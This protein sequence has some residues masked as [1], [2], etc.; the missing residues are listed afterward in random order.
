MH[1]EG[2]SNRNRFLKF[3]TCQYDF[4]INKQ[5]QIMNNSNIFLFRCK[6]NVNALSALKYRIAKGFQFLLCAGDAEHIFDGII[7]SNIDEFKLFLSIVAAHCQCE[8]IFQTNIRALYATNANVV[9]VHQ[10]CTSPIVFPHFECTVCGSC[11]HHAAVRMIHNNATDFFVVSVHWPNGCAF[12]S[13][14]AVV[15]FPRV[16]RRKIIV[17]IVRIP[18]H[19]FDFTAGECPEFETAVDRI[20]IAT[21]EQFHCTVTAAGQQHLRFG[22]M[23][24]QCLN[25]FG[26]WF[27]R[28]VR[29]SFV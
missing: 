26:K 13:N 7:V 22:L 1:F 24:F 16:C 20:W 9:L 29:F 11:G 8:A 15:N 17:R 19:T 27:Y 23:E 2:R 25:F 21:I 18:L 10:L 4:I 14:I 12:L 3:Q 6:K 28:C 5:K